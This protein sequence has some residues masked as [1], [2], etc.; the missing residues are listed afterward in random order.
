MSLEQR[1][2]IARE[3]AE[4]LAQRRSDMDEQCLNERTR[5]AEANGRLR[6][7]QLSQPSSR[8]DIRRL[9]SQLE[10]L[11]ARY[12]ATAAELRACRERASRD[13]TRIA[14]TKA[15]VLGEEEARGRAV[16]IA[17]KRRE[18]LDEALNDF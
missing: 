18:E 2:A 15:D 4:G 6:D 1:L 5:L 16:E 12:S 8:E 17:A 9:Q 7:L 3:E 11:A 14:K 13:E 10:T